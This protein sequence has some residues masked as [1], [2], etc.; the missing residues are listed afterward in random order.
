MASLTKK[1]GSKFWFACFRDVNG[2]QRRKSTRTAT[3]QKAVLIARQYEGVG[4]KKLPP[5]T[6][7]ETLAELYR[8]IYGEELKAATARQF[9]ASWLKTKEPETAAATLASYRKS[10]AKFLEYLGPIADLDLAAI[11]QRL[12]VEFRNSLLAK[13]APA[14]VNADLKAVKMVCRAAKRDGYILEDPSAFV[15]SVRD[16]DRESKRP[17][18]IPEIQRVLEASDPEWTALILWGLYSGQRLADLAVLTWD[19][20]DLDRGEIRLR[21]RKTNKQLILPIAAPLRIHLEKWPCSDVPGEP[22]HPRAFDTVK[23]QERVGNLSNQFADLL[24]AAGLREKKKHLKTKEGRDAK[25]QV[26]PLSFHSLRRTATSLLHEAGIPAAVAQALIGHD[27]EATHQ[28][29]ITVG[30]EALEKAAAAFPELL[31]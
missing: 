8:E 5:R 13:N 12:V 1:K 9:I 2:R 26:E 30:R 29:Y 18:T 14:T 4:Q 23:R 24:A 3:R 27:S 28:H 16:R 10:T 20:V 7:R 17:F 6:V 19:N 21:T 25:R 31:K 11:T 15:D 22:L